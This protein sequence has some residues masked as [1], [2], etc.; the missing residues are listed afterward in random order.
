MP[1]VFRGFHCG[2]P[3]PLD[4]TLPLWLA[5]RCTATNQGVSIFSPWHFDRIGK[6]ENRGRGMVEEWYIVCK[7][8]KHERQLQTA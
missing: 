7:K 5:N 4:R 6:M 1:R 3:E 8:D 2:Q